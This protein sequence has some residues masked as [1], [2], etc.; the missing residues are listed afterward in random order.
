MAIRLRKVRGYIVALC[1][2]ASVAKPGDV[3][4]DDAQ[5]EALANKFARDDNKMLQ[6]VGIDYRLPGVWDDAALVAAEERRPI[7]TRCRA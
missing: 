7:E 3:Y 2:A 1:A 4:I 5:H 6:A